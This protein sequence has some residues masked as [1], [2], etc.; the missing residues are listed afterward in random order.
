MLLFVVIFLI[1]IPLLFLI[2][3]SNFG[4]IYLISVCI[5]THCEKIAWHLARDYG[6]L[7]QWNGK[8]PLTVACAN[9]LFNFLSV[10]DFDTR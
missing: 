7:A 2:D 8:A 9:P 5:H 10:E 6:L 3:I 1:S 4:M